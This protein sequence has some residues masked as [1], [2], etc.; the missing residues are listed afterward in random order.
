MTHKVP[1]T[2]FPNL[3]LPALSSGPQGLLLAARGRWYVLPA[4]P[5]VVT[6]N[7]INLVPFLTTLRSSE[8]RV[9]PFLGPAA[10]ARF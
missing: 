9:I 8:S 4:E 1:G 5:P 10:R 6:L 7:S 3:W 2:P